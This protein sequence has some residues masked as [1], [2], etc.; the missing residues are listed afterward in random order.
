MQNFEVAGAKIS[1]R[2]PL[3]QIWPSLT[4]VLALSLLRTSHG[5]LKVEYHLEECR[6]R[7]LKLEPN[8]F[9]TF[10]A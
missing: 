5:T 4:P 6:Q 7:D 1:D 10:A 8:A 2:G 3:N 9:E